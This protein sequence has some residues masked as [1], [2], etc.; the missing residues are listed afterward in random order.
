M[1]A[2]IITSVN[3][4]LPINTIKTYRHPHPT[5][6]PKTKLKIRGP[7]KKKKIIR[8]G[9]KKKKT[10]DFL[11]FITPHSDNPITIHR[12][13]KN[14]TYALALILVKHILPTYMAMPSP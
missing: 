7:Q 11:F 12:I 10:R 6:H 2:L 14:S 13:M 9:R 3:D 5:H 8:G 4:T 1:T